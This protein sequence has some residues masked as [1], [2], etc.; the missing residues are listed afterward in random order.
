MQSTDSTFALE[1]PFGLVPMSM[2]F[3]RN[4]QKPALDC[5]CYNTFTLVVAGFTY[6][7]SP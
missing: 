7:D 3:Y 2:G 1:F 5:V 4:L 6:G